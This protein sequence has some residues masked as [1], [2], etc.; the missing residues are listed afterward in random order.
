MS[1]ERTKEKRRAVLSSGTRK[2]LGSDNLFNPSQRNDHML[3]RQ[4]RLVS[5]EDGTATTDNSCSHRRVETTFLANSKRFFT[6]PNSHWQHGRHSIT[7]GG[8]ILFILP[9]RQ[10]EFLTAS[11]PRASI[12]I[13]HQTARRSSFSKASPEPS[14]L[15]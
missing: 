8:G 11:T 13:Q 9:F 7:T 5:K 6:T 15:R 1:M 12:S 2:N 14:H 4:M 10:A 3:H